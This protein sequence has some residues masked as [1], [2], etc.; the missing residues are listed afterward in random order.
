VV[1]DVVLAVVV[2]GV[3]GAGATTA[4]C[5]D[6]ATVVPFLFVAVMVTRIVEPLSPARRR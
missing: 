4:V 6:V 3:D 5:C 1:V 2:V